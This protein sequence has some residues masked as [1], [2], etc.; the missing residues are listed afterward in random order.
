[1][2][3]IHMLS[4]LQNKLQYSKITQNQIALISGSKELNQK[5]GCRE[6]K[7]APGIRLCLCALPR[8]FGIVLGEP[9]FL[10]LSDLCEYTM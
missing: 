3:S 5:S 10:S 8:S 2:H 4:A 7:E 1:M 9:V 6:F